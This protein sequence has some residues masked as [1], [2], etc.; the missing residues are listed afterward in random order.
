[1]T[2]R[3]GVAISVGLLF[4][5][6]VYIYLLLWTPIVCYM[7]VVVTYA[8]VGFMHVWYRIIVC[9]KSL[10]LSCKIFQCFCIHY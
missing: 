5:Y 2:Q 3:L 1:M 8:I 6:C 7:Y 9:T 10:N 4:S